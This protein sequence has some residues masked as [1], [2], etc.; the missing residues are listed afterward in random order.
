VRK[1]L[2]FWQPL[3]GPLP[4]FPCISSIFPF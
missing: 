2:S 4:T 3:L 1:M